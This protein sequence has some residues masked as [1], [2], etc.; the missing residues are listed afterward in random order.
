MARHKGLFG[1]LG[2]LPQEQ[3]EELYDSKWG[4]LAA[5]RYARIDHTGLLDLT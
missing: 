3:V 1:F 5:F 4:A 2:H